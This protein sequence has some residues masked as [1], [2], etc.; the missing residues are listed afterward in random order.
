MSDWEVSPEFAEPVP[1]AARRSRPRRRRG[2]RQVL[3]GTAKEPHTPAAPPTTMI[4]IVE[5]ADADGS[6]WSRVLDLLLDAGRQAEGPD[7]EPLRALD[8]K[9]SPG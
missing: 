2:I 4:V 7:D 5:R 8:E 1:A 3:T 6:R 9:E